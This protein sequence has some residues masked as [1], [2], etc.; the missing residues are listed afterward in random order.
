MCNAP[1]TTKAGP[2]PGPSPPTGTSMD[3]HGPGVPP[4]PPPNQAPVST[5]GVRTPTA[6]EVPG[7]MP[8]VAHASSSLISSISQGIRATS[9]AM[10]PTSGAPAC[11]SPVEV[12]KECC[13]PAQEV[14]T[15]LAGEMPQVT[16]HDDGRPAADAPELAAAVPKV[17]SKKRSRVESHQPSGRGTAQYPR[18]LTP[19]HLVP[20]TELVWPPWNA[21][22]CMPCTRTVFDL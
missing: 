2:G 22:C 13:T 5:P 14:P 21:V 9:T 15:L 10:P 8:E 3:L 16:A 20:S 17:G 1:R 18:L 4:V 6:V 11:G 7:P 19:L 12:A